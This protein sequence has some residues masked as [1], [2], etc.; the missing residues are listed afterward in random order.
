MKAKKKLLHIHFKVG[1]GGNKTSA[2]HR[3][4]HFPE[5]NLILNQ[6][7][8]CVIQSKELRKMTVCPRHRR[9]FTCLRELSGTCQHPLHKEEKTKLKK[10]KKVTADISEKIH[11]ETW[12]DTHCIA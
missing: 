2:S 7:G 11:Q 6:A 10:P 9:K 12:I 5:Y 4:R 3:V 1:N 8:C